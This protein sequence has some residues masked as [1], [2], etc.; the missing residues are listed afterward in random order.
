MISRFRLILSRLIL[1]SFLTFIAGFSILSAHAQQTLPKRLIADYGYWSRT[2]TPPYS[3]A[4]I[5]FN[6]LTHINHAGVS[7]AGDG[8]LIVPE[9]FLEPEL[10]TKAHAA[11]VKVLLLLGGDFEGLEASQSA[12]SLVENAGAFATQ[13]GYD[14]FDMDWEYPASTA[15]RIFFDRLMALFRAANSNYLL[16]IDVGPWGGYGWDLVNLQ[17]S[18]SWFNIMMFDC[19]GPW[20][21]YGQLNSA[22]YWNW[23]DPSPSECQPGGSA[24]GAASI[25]L[26]QVPPDQITMG[27]PFYGY[28]YTNINAE[29]GRCPN[30]YWTS[31]QN[32]DYTVQTLNYGTAIKRRIN[33]EGWVSYRDPI[34]FVPYLLMA[35]GSPGYITYDDAFST[36]YRTWYS[37]W[38]R[39][40]GGSWMWSLDA[41]Y[42]GHSQDLLTAMYQATMSGPGA[43]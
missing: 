6:E 30:S 22:I 31:D 37:D 3:S 21:A 4:Q 18:I 25:F 11:G 17:T 32:C 29:F 7:F 28:Y 34:A 38:E 41:D 35:D 12:N 26:A 43:K 27:M 24:D 8:R 5:P 16:S 14:G 19:A 1:F 39:G 42:D 36:Y 33:N 2:Q 40:L 9:G 15:D 13:Y 20:T 10:I 23:H